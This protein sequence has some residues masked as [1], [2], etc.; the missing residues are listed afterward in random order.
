MEDGLTS[1][2]GRGNGPLVGHV[3]NHDIGCRAAVGGQCSLDP[4]MGTRQEPD[5]VALLDERSNSMRSDET[6]SPGD[7]DLR[8]ALLPAPLCDLSDGSARATPVV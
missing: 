2:D 5:L 3:S 7:Q 4:T 8:V 1:G 6:S